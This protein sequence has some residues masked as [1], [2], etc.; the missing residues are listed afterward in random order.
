MRREVLVAADHGTLGVPVLQGA[1]TAAA[2]GSTKGGGAMFELCPLE[3][4]F[5]GG[6]GRREAG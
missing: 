4:Q 1:S 5:T 2:L 3:G 6:V